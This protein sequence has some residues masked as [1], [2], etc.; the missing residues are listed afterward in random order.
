MLG[1]VLTCCNVAPEPLE[2]LDIEANIQRLDDQTE[3]SISRRR[4]SSLAEWADYDPNTDDYDVTTAPLLPALEAP[5]DTILKQVS[6]LRGRIRRG[7]DACVLQ[8]YQRV[9]QE[10]HQARQLVTTSQ[11]ADPRRDCKH[12]GSEVGSEGSAETDSTCCNDDEF[13]V[14]ETQSGTSD[15][16]S[17]SSHDSLRERM[18]WLVGDEIAFG[19][20]RTQFGTGYL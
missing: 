12:W 11:A 14:E 20:Q 13:L 15:R 16:P 4:E 3:F 17:R 2:F 6:A 9:I 8:H 5:D 7:G 18:L 19:A 1:N 10:L